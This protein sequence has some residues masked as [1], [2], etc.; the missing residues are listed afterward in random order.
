MMIEM[1]IEITI[2]MT[3]NIDHPTLSLHMRTF[4]ERDPST[5]TWVRL[6]PS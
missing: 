6:L 2:E 5:Q 1:T 3:K 4:V